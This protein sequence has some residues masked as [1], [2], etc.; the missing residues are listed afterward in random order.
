MGQDA[1][2]TQCGAPLGP[3]GRFCEAC[4]APAMPAWAPQPAPIEH[5]PTAA[6]AGRIDS[7]EAA[8]PSLP[9]V[10]CQACGYVLEPGLNFCPGCGSPAQPMPAQYSTAPAR[11]DAPQKAMIGIPSPETIAS[12]PSAVIDTASRVDR[13]EAVQ[14]P[15]V[16][17][18]AETAPNRSVAWVPLSPPAPD[19]SFPGESQQ[20]EMRPVA[21][22]SAAPAKAP[23]RL[24]YLPFVAASGALLVVAAGIFGG[25]HWWNT[26]KY[27]VTE[28]SSPAPEPSATSGNQ[29]SQA[30]NPPLPDAPPAVSPPAA[31]PE[32]PS[33]ASPAP[34]PSATSGNQTPQAINPPLPNAPPAVSPAAAAPESPSAASSA[35]P[36]TDVS[37]AVSRPKIR[38]SAPAS[39]SIGPY[40]SIDVEVKPRILEQV[41]PIYPAE[42]KRRRIED[43]I[44]LRL[45]I[46][47]KGSVEEVQFLRRARKERAFDDAALKAVKQWRFAAAQKKGRRV[48][49]WFNVAVP[50]FLK[51]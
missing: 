27:Q 35:P 25:Y 30:I 26:H 8:S 41:P 3:A 50:F 12:V 23:E 10:T 19:S 4:G 31:A 11:P 49:C 13:P 32:S 42:A 20:E 40:E 29:T 18:P 14:G 38:A 48:A 51:R 44:V 36:K 45:L 28:V 2:C 43:T 1:F 33:A 39:T 21:Q 17:P 7:P 5:L 24:R 15:N 16:V 9:P 22:P 47:E 37:K 34:E 6:P 46:S